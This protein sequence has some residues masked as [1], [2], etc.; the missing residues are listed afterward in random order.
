MNWSKKK[1]ELFFQRTLIVPM[2]NFLRQGLSPQ[3]LALTI[4]LGIVLGVFPILGVTTVLCAIAAVV[5]KL[6]L[7]A[8]Q[9]V[10]YFV[11]PLQL[12]LLIPHVRAGELLFNEPPLSLDVVQIIALIQTNGVGAANELWSTAFHAVVAWMIIGLPLVVVLYAI[13]VPL[14]VRRGSQTTVTEQ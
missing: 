2:I 14:L 7:P 1:I 5:F 8:I 13:L 4:A 9:L 10:N 6:N 3:K 11:S 12:I